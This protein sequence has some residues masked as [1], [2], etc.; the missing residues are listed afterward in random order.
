MLNDGAALA[1]HHGSVYKG[2]EITGG[3]SLEWHW[4]KSPYQF[5][6]NP[7]LRVETSFVVAIPNKLVHNSIQG[8]ILSDTVG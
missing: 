5:F 3:A 1:A 4:G 2:I 7:Q 8:D 6:H